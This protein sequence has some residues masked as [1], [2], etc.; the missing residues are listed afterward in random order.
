MNRYIVELR[1]VKTIEFNV[2]AGSIKEAEKII[3]NVIMFNDIVRY[4]EL[5][6][7][8]SE[9]FTIKGRKANRWWAN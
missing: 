8:Q 7:K 1:Q 4:V 9:T 3:E 6:S 5:V 2:E